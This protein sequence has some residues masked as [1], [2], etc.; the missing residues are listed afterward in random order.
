MSAGR[1]RQ[2][3]A[4]GLGFAI[5]SAPCAALAAEAP[6]GA[7]SCSGC[8]AAQ[9]RAGSLVPVLHGRPAEEIGTAMLDF[10]SGARPGTV[11]GR[12]AKGFSENEIGALADW[13]SGQR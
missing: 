12:I 9:A 10:R 4:L 1:R 11:M 6:A 5:L 3:I 8:H 2:C 7:A 13:F